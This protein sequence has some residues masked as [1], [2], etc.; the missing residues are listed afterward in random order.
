LLVSVR[1]LAEARIAV[2]GGVDLL[3]LKEPTRGSLGAVDPAIM[4]QVVRLIAGRIPVSMALGELVDL[5][6]D[7]LPSL[8]ISPGLTYVKAGLARC[9]TQPDWPERFV[10]LAKSLPVDT[11]L[12]AVVYADGPRVGAPDLD[13]V[14]EVTAA[15]GC[16]AVLVDTA[17]KDGRGLLDHWS[18]EVVR[19]FIVELRRRGL[20]SVVGGSLHSATLAKVAALKPDYVAVR[21]AV[22][23]GDRA[24]SLHRDKLR[25][26]RDAVNASSLG[27]RAA[28]VRANV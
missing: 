4:E 28:R 12:V 3:D 14:L 21:G 26:V 2:D 13:E 17:I 22:C 7:D 15:A 1:D 10:A 9:A 25:E 20:T 23:R 11:S 18:S 8:A 19:K 5:P 27:R 6:N 16:R 24:Q